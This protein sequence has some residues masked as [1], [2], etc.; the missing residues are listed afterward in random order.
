MEKAFL[1]T[2]A[3]EAKECFELANIAPLLE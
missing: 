3:D 1:Q 2:E